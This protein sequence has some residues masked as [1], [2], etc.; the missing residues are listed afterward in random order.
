MRKRSRSGSGSAALLL[1]LAFA[2]PACQ[3]DSPFVA[4]D[5]ALIVRLE[6][7]VYELDGVHDVPEGF[8]PGAPYATVE[9]RED[10]ADTAVDGQPVADVLAN[11]ESTFLSAGTPL[12]VIPGFEATERLAA[13]WQGEWEV[14]RVR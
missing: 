6:D 3:A 12:H 8:A 13:Q 1:V 14:L 2:A 7:R 5:C 10:C 9:K 11:G 4:G